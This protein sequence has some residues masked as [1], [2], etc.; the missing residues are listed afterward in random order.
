[1]SKPIFSETQI[2]KADTV[3]R[4]MIDLSTKFHER[5][6]KISD[7]FMGIPFGDM[8]YG[9]ALAHWENNGRPHNAFFSYAPGQE[10]CPF[11]MEFAQEISDHF[12]LPILTIDEGQK[13]RAREQA[14]GF[15]ILTHK[16]KDWGPN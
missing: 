6:R 14:R 10:S 8:A 4:F 3:S 12:S 16:V 11:L 7:K 15:S 2:R 13:R 5:W 1:M 9:A